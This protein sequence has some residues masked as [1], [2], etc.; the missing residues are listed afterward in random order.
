MCVCV[1]CVYSGIQVC[2]ASHT[3]KL[4][5][6]Q[7]IHDHDFDSMRLVQRTLKLSVYEC[8]WRVRGE[9]TTYGTTS[10]YAYVRVH[11]IR[12]IRIRTQHRWNPLRREV[13]NG[14]HSFTKSCSKYSFLIFSTEFFNLSVKM[15]YIMLMIHAP[16][17]KWNFNL[18]FESDFVRVALTRLTMNGQTLACSVTFFASI[19]SVRWLRPNVARS[20]HARHVAP[21]VESR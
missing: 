11:C 10:T 13:G 14:E 20:Q 16:H 8:R 5:R 17:Y 3:K 19:G 2:S 1:V 4:K 12:R 6:K 9:F 7:R 15:F 18:P 21:H